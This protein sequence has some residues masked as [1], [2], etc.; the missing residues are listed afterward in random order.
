MGDE[1]ILTKIRCKF[2]NTNRNHRLMCA[3]CSMFP[4]VA[5]WRGDHILSVLLADSKV[6][7]HNEAIQYPC[8]FRSSLL[9]A[10]MMGR[11]LFAVDRSVHE[12]QSFPDTFEADFFQAERDRPAGQGVTTPVASFSEV[13]SQ[14]SDVPTPAQPT[15]SFADPPGAAS[16][17]ASI[18]LTLANTTYAQTLIQAIPTFDGN[19][20]NY[21]NWE[22]KVRQAE[23][24]QP[25]K[26]L[27]LVLVKQK[28]GPDPTMFV[29]TIGHRADRLSTLLASLRGRFYKYA[30]EAFAHKELDDIV[31][32][33]RS[34]GEY[35]AEFTKCLRAAGKE[36][37]T[38]DQFQVTHYIKGFKS[39]SFRRWLFK[40]KSKHTQ[41]PLS[42][43]LDLTYQSEKLDHVSGE[44]QGRRQGEE[45][46][47]DRYE[48]V[49][50]ARKSTST[51]S[52]EEET[53]GKEKV[54]KADTARKET[55]QD[56][57]SQPKADKPGNDA[58]R[59]QG[60]LKQSH[61]PIHETHSH[62]L[63]DCRAKNSTT[64][65]W[66][67]TEVKAGQLAYHMPKCTAKR[68]YECG[69]LGHTVVQCKRDRNDGTYQ[70]AKKHIPAGG[71]FNFRRGDRRDDRHDFRRDFRD[72]RCDFHRDDKGR[73]YRRSRSCS[74]K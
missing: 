23:T 64:C 15:V 25:N 4:V 50:V 56:N 12:W 18:A 20:R 37:T 55:V 3:R 22:T 6:E 49:R 74:P 68:C 69:R 61:C 66:C 31:Q 71:G 8:Q 48:A 26:A 11:V 52:S 30:D 70:A 73:K 38:T 42:L 2:C 17:A 51:Q 67:K 72:F 33:D 58:Q 1:L 34:I 59:N 40:E 57:K 63:R 45:E 27:F 41:A 43:Y 9:N 10:F 7:I 13:Q 62:D 29:E 54:C 60:H 24:Y 39:Q 19:S 14:H 44:P 53:S 36:I 35:N 21:H 46:D 47:E 5:K 16:E 32:G 65:R 28:L